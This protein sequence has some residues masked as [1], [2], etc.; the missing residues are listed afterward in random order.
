[1][2]LFKGCPRTA[3]ILC[4]PVTLNAF[5]E[6]PQ[7][8]IKK[9]KKGKHRSV[10]LIFTLRTDPGLEPLTDILHPL[11]PVQKLNKAR[12]EQHWMRN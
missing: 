12:D 7:I 6:T 11:L 3:F 4:D 10:L 9:K 1:M 2:C 8:L 5:T